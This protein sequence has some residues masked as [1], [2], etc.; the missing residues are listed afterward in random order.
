MK[1]IF[2]NMIRFFMPLAMILVIS[3]PAFSQ[4]EEAEKDLRPVKGMFE[5]NWL[6]DN[7]TA[8]VP[9]KGTF[10]MDFNHRF[11]LANNGLEDFF[12]LYGSS[13]IRLGFSFVPIERLQVGFGVTRIN[14]TW[15]FNAKYAL[16]RQARKGGS[17]VALTYFVN[18]AIETADVPGKYANSTDRYSYFHQLIL[19]RKFTDN[20]SF[21]MAGSVSHYNAV[22]ADADGN[23]LIEND[24]IA[25]AFSTR[26]KLGSWVNFIANVD[27]PVTDHFGEGRD[28]EPNISFGL[29]LTS[30][31]HQFQIFTGNFYG[32]NPQRNNVFNQN[33]FGD[34]EILIGFN[35]TR[36]WNF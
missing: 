10:E 9:Y 6:I 12:G 15:D 14:M 4:E 31:S 16:L 28:P 25:L 5:S 26:Y 17:P 30:S 32:I 36:L 11:G 13:N 2:F 23:K 20:F 29:E 34:S 18:T 7:Q 22:D 21:Q 8:I 24:H 35:I 27:V 19:G 1:N 3:I 33:R